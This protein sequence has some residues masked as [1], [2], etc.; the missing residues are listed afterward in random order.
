MKK[1]FSFITGALMGGL[2]GATAALLLAPSTGEELRGQMKE[3]ISTFQD[4]MGQA[5]N[6]RKVELEKKLDDMRK[7]KAPQVTQ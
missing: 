7:P 2:V 5:M 3:R 4:E 6:S 1:M